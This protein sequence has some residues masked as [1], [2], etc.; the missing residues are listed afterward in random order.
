MKL[1]QTKV[2]FFLLVLISALILQQSKAQ[3]NYCSRTNID[4]IPGCFHALQL[5]Y[6]KDYSLLTRNCC[7]AV[8]SLPTTCALLVYPGKTYPITTFRLICIYSDPL[9][10][11]SPLSL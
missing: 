10:A 3:K 8:F 4:Y 6:N 5:A 7:R 9:P 11:M 2:M 1:K